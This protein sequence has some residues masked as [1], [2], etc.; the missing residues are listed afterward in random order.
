MDRNHSCIEG[1]EFIDFM[2]QPQIQ[3]LMSR[4]VGT[5]PIVPKETTDLTDEEFGFV[6]SEID[7]IIPNYAVQ[8]QKKGT[9]VMSSYSIYIRMPLTRS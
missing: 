1:H 3:A 4:M 6:S 2:C 7:P 9:R 8:N 5:A